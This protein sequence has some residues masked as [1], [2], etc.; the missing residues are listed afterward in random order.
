MSIPDIAIPDDLLPHDG[1]FGC[2]PS[3]IRPES[4]EMLAG[5]APHYMGT[6]HRQAGVRFKV[7]ELRNGLAEM[8]ALPYLSLGLTTY[9]SAIFNFVPEFALDFYAAVRSNDTAHVRTALNDFVIPY[10]NLRNQG[11][12]YAVSIV[13]AGMTAIGRT[14][15]PVRPPVTDLSPSQLAEL[16]DLVKKVS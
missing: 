4:I 15:G 11:A 2:G 13:K 6:S 1:R 3:R 12:G 5:S 16:T 9:S 14:A 10:C 7:G 8:F